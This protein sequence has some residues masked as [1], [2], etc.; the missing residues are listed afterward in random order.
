[1]QLMKGRLNVTEHNLRGYWIIHPET[2]NWSP[3]SMTANV[4]GSVSATGLDLA[5]SGSGLVQRW[6]ILSEEE[7]P[8]VDSETLGV[9]APVMKQDAEVEHAGVYSINGTRIRLHNSVE[10]LPKGLYIVGGKKVV[11]K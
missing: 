6:L 8:F 2:N 4:N 10:G 11:V 1:M 7:L 3:S 9:D 5:N